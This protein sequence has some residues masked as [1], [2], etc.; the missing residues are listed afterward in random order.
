MA[1]PRTRFVCRGGDLGGGE[2]GGRLKAQLR[3]SQNLIYGF[4][5]ASC[6]NGSNRVRRLGATHPTIGSA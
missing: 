5:T 2:T 4:Q 3:R 6:L 1:Q